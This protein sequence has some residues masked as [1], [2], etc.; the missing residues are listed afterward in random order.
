MPHSQVYKCFL[1]LSIIALMLI[2]ILVGITMVGLGENDI[3]PFAEIAKIL[4]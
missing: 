3:E 4:L 1:V 2:G